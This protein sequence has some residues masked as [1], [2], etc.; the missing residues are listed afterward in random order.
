MDMN[1]RPSPGSRREALG[2]LRTL[3]A[4]VAVA[5]IAATAGFGF[6]AASE[7]NGSSGRRLASSS[8][9]SRDQGAR[10]GQGAATAPD[11]QPATDPQAG[12]GFQIPFF[13]NGAQ[14]PTLGSGRSHVTTGAS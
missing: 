8:G 7:T 4:G 1:D 13:G 3:T 12:D 10:S 2:R 5:G 14:A 11:R 9:T 6:V